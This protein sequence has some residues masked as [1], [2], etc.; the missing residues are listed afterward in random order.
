MSDLL[1]NILKQSRFSNKE[2][3]W[4]SLNPKDLQGKRLSN[5]W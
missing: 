5:Y 4:S 2:L 3:E 1:E